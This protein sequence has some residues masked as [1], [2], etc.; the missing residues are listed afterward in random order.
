MESFRKCTQCK[1]NKQLEHYTK[2]NKIL[3]LC[4]KCRNIGNKCRNKAKCIHGKQKSQCKHCGVGFCVHD[5]RKTQC[6]DCGGVSICVHGKRKS[7]C[8]E[9]GGSSI[10]PHDKIKAQCID[11]GGVN[12]C[13]HGKFKPQCR[14]CDGCSFCPHKLRK[15]QCK[16]CRDP[17]HITILNMIQSSKQTDKK[18]NRYDESEFVDYQYLFNLIDI[19]NDECFYCECKLQ[20]IEFANNMAT[21]ERL[22]NDI[23][24]NKKN[25]VIACRSCNYS[26]IGHR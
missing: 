22:D 20:Y 8:H 24:H 4:L 1:K 23:G 2:G 16:S 6:V 14:E 26:N 12:V 18:K 21:I 5:K 3:K 10:C 9:C 19:S 15:T 25:I 17:I 13:I 11:C 7:T